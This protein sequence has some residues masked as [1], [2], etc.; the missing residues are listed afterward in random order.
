MGFG[1]NEVILRVDLSAGRTSVTSFEEPFWRQYPG[2]RAFAVQLLLRE[3]PANV[4]PLGPDNVLILAAGLLTGAPVSTATRFSAVARSPL[5]GAFGE[6]EAGGF[7]GPELKM[8]G[9]DAVVVSGRAPEPVYLWIRDGTAE[10]RH[11][12]H[13][14]GKSPPVVQA[15]IREEVGEKHAKVL[16]IGPAGE[17]GVLYAI[18][19]NELRHYNGRTGMGAVMGAKN[20]RAIAVRGSGRYLDLAHDPA[21]LAALGRR[22]SQKVKDDP[23]SWDLR[24]KGTLVLTDTLTAAGILPTQNFRQG[25][26]ER[27]DEIRTAAYDRY[28]TGQRSCYACAVRCKPQVEVDDRYRVTDTYDGPEY[29][30]VAGF[31]SDCGVGDLQAVMKANELCNEHGIDVISA[32]ATIA[33]AMECFEHGLIGPADTD[34]LELRFGNAEAMLR[35]VEMIARRE[36]IGDLL[37]TGA[38]RAAE[39]IGGE[40]RDLAMHVKGQELPMH[41]PR[42]KT[43]VAFGYATNEAGADHLVAFHDGIFR[44]P[45]S[46]GFR[47]AMP[48]G[49]SEPFDPLEFSAAKVH[50]WFLGEAWTS[51]EKSI[52]FCYFG[53][54]PRSFIPVDDVVAAVRA[55]TGWEV[56]VDELLAVGERATNLAR[57]F[58]AREGFSRA[59]DRLPPRLFAPLENGPLAGTAIDRDAFE[60]ALTDLYL[61]KGWDPATGLPTRERLRRLDIEWSADLAGVA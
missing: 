11:A 61:A 51:C 35:A 4:D 38:R 48:L 31:G 8:A 15:G 44:D 46:L 36:G 43:G 30:S 10:I 37:A 28:R 24:T 12:R 45:A 40:A 26:F 29:E 3:C 49:I 55:A 52:G 33:F 18:L 6:S 34:G 7:W 32:S 41:D 42:G 47:S 59:D 23:R 54:S 22:L 9:F 19:M 57:V 53:P 56:T 5:T 17:R 60:R 39:V 27:I 14:W 16:Q 50:A 20:L 2:G 21:A 13:L 25:V 1:S 58:N